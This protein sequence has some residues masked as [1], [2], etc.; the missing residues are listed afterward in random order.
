MGIVE[1]Y[2]GLLVS[3]IFLGVTGE[4]LTSV[5]WDDKDC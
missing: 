2:H 1:N 3:R 5:P 4:W